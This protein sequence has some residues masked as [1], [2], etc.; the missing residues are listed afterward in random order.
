MAR[1]W[2]VESGTFRGREV[3]GVYESLDVIRRI[4]S[5]DWHKSAAGWWTTHN[6]ELLSAWPE[7]VRK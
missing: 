4:F 7:R 5:S 1:V 2:I 6:G 3:I